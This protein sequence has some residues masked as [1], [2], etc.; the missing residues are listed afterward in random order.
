MRENFTH[1]THAKRL[2]ADIRNSRVLSRPR[3]ASAASRRD[4]ALV[5]V[6]I[7]PTR[8]SELL[9]LLNEKTQVRAD[10]VGW[11]RVYHIPDTTSRT[12]PGGS[13]RILASPPVRGNDGRE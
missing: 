5:R 13:A 7:R 11:D 3:I 1:G 8:G 4:V 12:P 10:L 2:E 6:V 9:T